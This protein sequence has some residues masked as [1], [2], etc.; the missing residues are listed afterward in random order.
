VPD[1][2]AGGA[3]GQVFFDCNTFFGLPAHRRPLLPCPT[4]HDL[5]DEMDRAGVRR[6]L[7]WH[8][9]Q[10][11][12]SAQTGNRLLAQGI[13]AHSRLW[14]CWSVLPPH[15]RELP[16]P[17]RLLAQMREARV[18]ALRVFPSAH[19]FVANKVSLG[20][21]LGAAVAH[22]IPLLISVK[23]GF[24]W[25]SVYALLAD[26]PELIC[27]ICDHG[28]WGMDR[29]FRP[30]LSQYPNVYVDTS[31]Y[32]V[33]G[34][35]EQLVADYGDGRLLYGSGFPESYHGGMMLV[36]RHA[37]I[38]DASKAAIAGGNLDRILA[39]VRH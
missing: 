22:R 6:A 1:A 38:P 24:D 13:A 2:S 4:A 11:D 9:A 17:P 20:Q 29:M 31:Q 7:A 27:V 23:R 16:D 30:L 26:F 10:H 18:V 3:G 28:C 35:I 5:I 12:A 21:L 39:E 19:R 37:E 32:M 36:L 34:G 33:D 14:G 25:P 15:T 8:I